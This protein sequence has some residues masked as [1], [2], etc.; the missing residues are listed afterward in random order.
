[1]ATKK[2]NKKIMNLDL[3]LSGLFI[4][5]SLIFFT[6]SSTILMKYFFPISYLILGV[7]FFV[8]GFNE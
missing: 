4:A 3:I 5:L 1:M 6:S 2:Q 7:W 8:R